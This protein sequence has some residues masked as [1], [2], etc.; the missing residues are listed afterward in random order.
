M[1]SCAHLQEV[2]GAREGVVRVVA[3]EDREGL[4]ARL[5]L[6]LAGLLA[7]LP[8][9]TSAEWD[10]LVAHAKRHGVAQGLE[11]RRLANIV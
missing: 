3:G 1:D 8:P 9:R 4:A 11:N 7:L 6:L 2:E 5:D 10:I